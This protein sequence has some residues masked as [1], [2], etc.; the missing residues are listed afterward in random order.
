[1]DDEPGRGTPTG[2]GGGGG[3]GGGDGGPGT[4]GEPTVP[5]GHPETGLAPGGDGTPVVLFGAA[6]LAL[7]GAAVAFRRV[8]PRALRL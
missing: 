6:F 5:F 4:P 8:A 7:V 2:G 3:N 1:D